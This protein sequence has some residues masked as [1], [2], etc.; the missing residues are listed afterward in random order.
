LNSLKA[1]VRVRGFQAIDQRTAGAQELIAWRGQLVADL[2]GE[3]ELTAAKRA[4]IDARVLNQI[5]LERRARKLPDLEAYLR[6]CGREDGMSRSNFVAGVSGVVIA[7]LL[8]PGQAGAKCASWVLW[9]NLARYDQ[10]TDTTYCDI[11]TWQPVDVYESSGLCKTD[12]HLDQPVSKYGPTKWQDRD[13]L[14]LPSRHFGPARPQERPVTCVGSSY[15]VA[16]CPD[17]AA[18]FVARELRRPT[19]GARQDC[20]GGCSPFFQQNKGG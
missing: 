10:V 20:G 14:P 1:R 8:M 9:R 11:R 7:V 19:A 17:C 15:P 18:G 5:G 13:H 12:A 16:N 3:E 2:G 6:D 4:L